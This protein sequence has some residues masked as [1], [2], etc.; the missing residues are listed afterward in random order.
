MDDKLFRHLRFVAF[1]VTALG[2]VCLL[3]MGLL[4]MLLSGFLAYEL[5]HRI[6][7]MAI[8]V[9][10]HESKRK[11]FAVAAIGASVI[12]ML[13]LI[14]V[15][16]FASVRS[17]I[18][19]AGMLA[20]IGE[21][22]ASLRKL[23][24][25]NMAD[26]IPA[27]DVVFDQASHLFKEHAA[28]MGVAGL[29][30]LKEFG[31]ALV[32]LLLGLMMAATGFSAGKP[33]GPRSVELMGQVERM[34]G[35]FWQVATAQFKI[36]VAN[37]FF[38]A[39]YLLAV[40]P[41]IGVQLPFK[42]TLVLVAFLTGL[43]PVAGNLISNA[44]ITLISIGYSLPVAMGSLGFL[45]GIHKLEYFLNAKIVS[46]NIDAKAWEILLSIILMEHLFGVAGVVA[47]PIFYAWMK[48]EWHFWDAPMASKPSILDTAVTADATHVA[49]PP[50]VAS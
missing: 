32:G 21:I 42:K 43:I 6:G 39:I 15:A 16:I 5:V 14:G 19:V 11:M 7:A 12:A 44:A 23:L 38:T 20:K 24:P 28:A 18:D 46:A 1:I 17:G 29:S 9:G 48:A 34:R 4:V 33:F 2:A 50:A 3:K 35:A 30:L 13:M 27:D 36:S 10:R 25:A 40:L 47:A 22:I 49:T 45:V 26:M 41:A 8:P 37:T 31:F